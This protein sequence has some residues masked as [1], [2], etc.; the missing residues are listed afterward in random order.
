MKVILPDNPIPLFLE[1]LNEAK[2]SEIN[3]PEAM[4]LATSTRD[5]HPNV[6]MVLL[7]EANEQGF[8]FHTDEQSAKGCEL[9]DNPRA[10][11]C[12]YWKSLRK[13]IR[14]TG[15]VD[16]VTEREA[17]EYFSTRPYA[18]QIGA[19]ASAQSRP[20]DSRATL[21]KKI[22]TL[23]KQYP[24]GSAIPRPAYWVGYRVVPEA[25]EFWWDNP[26]RLHDRIVYTRLR[27]DEWKTHRLYP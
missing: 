3:D 13:Q 22:E 19:H 1:W 2:S 21:E 8:K 7:K 23:Q 5:G 10:A 14:V 9:K 17:D 11:L 4:A 18:R 16:L 15:R 12:F 26:D 20:L 25:I 24:E 27:D 6:R